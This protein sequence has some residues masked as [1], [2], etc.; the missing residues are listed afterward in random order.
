[1]YL[2]AKEDASAGS[3]VFTVV[4]SDAAG[5]QLE[6]LALNA[7]VTEAENTGSVTRGLEI[8]LIV[9]LVILVI[10]GLVVLFSKMKGKESDDELEGET[11][12]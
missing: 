5:T 4:V 9:L 10:I 2:A 11:Y 1:M 6:Q 7:D 12:Y 3:K 8:G